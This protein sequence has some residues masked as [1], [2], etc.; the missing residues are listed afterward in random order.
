VNRPHALRREK[1]AILV[2]PNER[3][4]S[5]QLS[6][7][8]IA[9]A[10]NAGRLDPLAVMEA[11]VARVEDRNPTLNA[12]VSFD[13]KQA[14]KSAAALSARLRE[15]ERPILAGVPV[16]VKDNI[17]IAGQNITQGSPLFRD[18]CPPRSA[19]SV[20]RLTNAGAQVIGIGNMP[21]FGCKD[22]TDNRLYGAT[23]HPLDP[24][25]TPGGSSGGCASAVAA[26]MAPIALCGDGGG[27]ARRPAAHVGIVGFKPT[28]GVIAD[29]W[30]FPSIMP[31]IG[32]SCPMGR[33]V[34]DVSLMFEAM[35]GPHAEDALSLILPHVAL[36]D[37]TRLRVAWSP[38]LGLDIAVDS[39]VAD[40]VAG[41]VDQL[42]RAGLRV[43]AADPEWPSGTSEERI[44]AI[45]Q[46]GLAATFGDV[47][48][49]DPA[50]FDPHIGTQ[51]KSGQALTGVEVA[52]AWNASLELAACLA[53]FF[54]RFD[55]LLCP[56]TACVAWP[57]EQMTPER[58]GGGPSS[59][60]G[61][62]AFTPLFNH[63]RTPAI[64][65]P[66]G[67][68]RNGLPVGLQIIGARL[69]DRQVL[70]AAAWMEATLGHE[71]RPWLDLYHPQSVS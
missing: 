24:R 62:A 27:S 65:I 19:L 49:R 64:S 68:G 54:T 5:V 32:T 56:T 61:H 36:S 25:L 66:C 45:E 15:G 35:L 43:V 60:R 28:N 39:D 2:L 44:L 63:A 17:W 9:A 59:P 70:Q 4:V 38:R 7:L 33:T 69:S 48:C 21:E 37:V 30:G 1:S 31:G 50:L 11:F 20:V 10:V 22:V 29:P 23:R 41:A 53:T 6:A 26:D 40:A 55:L 47:W 3:D 71:A 52:R 12:L 18:F 8:E 16:V 57:L 34:A 51:I 13:R 67:A 42:Q 14:L 46:S 58:I